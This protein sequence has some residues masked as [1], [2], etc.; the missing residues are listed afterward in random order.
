[1]ATDNKRNLLYFESPSMHELYTTIQKWQDENLKRLLSLNIQKDR[2]LF[3]CVALSNPME[4]VITDDQGI[5]F[6]AVDP[7][8]RLCVRDT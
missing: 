7:D 8:K 2:G 5:Y 1:M 6:V 4:V 3:C